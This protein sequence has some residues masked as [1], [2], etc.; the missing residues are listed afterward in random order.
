MLVRTKVK[1]YGDALIG[2]P[3]RWGAIV[4]LDQW[5]PIGLGFYKHD[6]S[7]HI[8]AYGFERKREAEAWASDEARKLRKQL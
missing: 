6:I 4:L 1:R 5:M 3:I 7:G 2:Q 8:A